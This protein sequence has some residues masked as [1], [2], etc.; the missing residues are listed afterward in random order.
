MLIV[1]VIKVYAFFCNNLKQHNFF[2]NV[3][4]N[5]KNLFAI[6]KQAKVSILKFYKP[7]CELNCLCR[8]NLFLVCYEDKTVT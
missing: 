1:Y 5:L 8:N 6:L 2:D 4:Y 3:I 7:N